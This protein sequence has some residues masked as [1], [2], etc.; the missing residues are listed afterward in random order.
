[1]RVIFRS[2]SSA[3]WFTRSSKGTLLARL[4]R[5]RNSSSEGMMVLAI[6]RIQQMRSLQSFAMFLGEE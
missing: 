4:Y 1:M 6:L 5:S 2:F 3:K